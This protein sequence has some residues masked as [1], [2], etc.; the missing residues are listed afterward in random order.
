MQQ[1]CWS[2][3]GIAIVFLLGG[4]DRQQHTNDGIGTVERVVDGDTVDIRIDGTKER[5]RLIGI[6]TPETKNPDSPAECYGPEAST[7]TEGLLPVGTRVRLERDTVGRDHYGRLLGYVY[8]LDDN[9]F[10]NYNILR[11]GYAQP[12]AID[13][14]IAHSTTFATAARLAE[15]DNVGLWAA[16]AG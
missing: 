12:L 4:C 14:N 9:L 6:D 2:L 16:C 3:A 1:N 13:P 10:V 5:V 7:Y 11:Q 15:D 8:R